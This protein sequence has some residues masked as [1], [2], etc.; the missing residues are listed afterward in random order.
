VVAK[1]LLEANGDTLLSIEESSLA[2]FFYYTNI[3]TAV[4]LLYLFKRAFD[5]QELGQKYLDQLSK[6]SKDWTLPG[7]TS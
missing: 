7:L 3:I 2:R 6:K 5:V 4:G 1:V